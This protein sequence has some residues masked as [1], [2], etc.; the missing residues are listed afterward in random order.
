MQ[1]KSYAPKYIPLL[2]L[3]LAAGLLR[4]AFFNVSIRH[5]PVSSDEGITVLQAKQIRQGQT[6]LFFMG[7][8]YMFPTESYL[9]APFVRC[10]PRTTW[11]ARLMPCLTG[12]LGMLC[13]IAIAC[14]LAKPRQAWPALL[15]IAIP[16]SYL[17]I[18][19]A[20]YALPGYPSLLAGGALAILLALHAQR[21]WCAALSGLIMGVAFS[22][23]MLALPAAMAA[24]CYCLYRNRRTAGNAGIW[25]RH[26]PAAIFICGLGIG[27]LPW[28]LARYLHAA[29][30]STVLET[31]SLTQAVARLWS[32]AI[33]YT[34]PGAM[35]AAMVPFPDNAALHPWPWAE[36]VIA[37]G[38]LALLAIGAVIIVTSLARSQNSRR[39]PRL[40][41]FLPFYIMTASTLLIFA[42]TL[43]ADSNSFRYLLP[44]VWCFPFLVQHVFIESARPLKIMVGIMTVIL[45]TRRRWINPPILPTF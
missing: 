19:Q 10:L 13:T 39:G 34:L 42:A 25:R 12:L 4:I 2:L 8:P 41:P 20:A 40:T 11:G 9:Q 6:P 36:K 28:L 23:H 33:T 3:I 14:R 43:R 30:Q 38:W 26:I 22:T 29:S 18:H 7:Q 1:L 5:L 15:L 24:G 37:M 45:T 35:G 32:P 31:V 44:T 17:L 21:W 16:S 27:L